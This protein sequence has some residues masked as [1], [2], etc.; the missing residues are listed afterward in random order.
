MCPE[1][2]IPVLSHCAGKSR[3]YNNVAVWVRTRPLTGLS[4]MR[5]CE[6]DGEANSKTVLVGRFLPVA[7]MAFGRNAWQWNSPRSVSLPRGRVAWRSPVARTTGKRQN[8]PP[9]CSIAR[10]FRQDWFFHSFRGRQL[11]SCWNLKAFTW[12]QRSKSRVWKRARAREREWAPPCA[13]AVCERESTRSSGRVFRF[14]CLRS[15]CPSPFFWHCCSFAH[16][17]FFGARVQSLLARN[18]CSAVARIPLKVRACVC[19]S[20]PLP[21]VKKWKKQQ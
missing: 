17:L 7:R 6:R 18:G 15:V 20:D 14:K 10:A 16:S 12:P 2:P 11:S 4:A 3:L 21:P 9:A 5:G 19:V 8:T 13:R 1:F